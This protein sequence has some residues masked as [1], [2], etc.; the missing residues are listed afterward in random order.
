MIVVDRELNH[1][2]ICSRAV[3]VGGLP[4][5]WYGSRLS[6]FESTR[7][8]AGALQPLLE[9]EVGPFFAG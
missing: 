4:Q 8:P 1:L 2:E 6:D 5:I 7:C 3:P 9:A